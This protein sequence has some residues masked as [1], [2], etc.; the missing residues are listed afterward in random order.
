MMTFDMSP[1]FRS[2]VG[3]DALSRAI[4]TAISQT[5]SGYPPYNIEKTAEDSYRISLAVAGFTADDIEAITNEGV[6]T[7]RGKAKAE[8]GGAAYLYHGIAAR[9]F[10]RRFQLADY[11]EVSGARL[12]NGMLRIDLARRVPEELKARRVE[13]VTSAVGQTASNTQHQIGVAA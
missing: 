2:T 7:V 3:F 4:D 9:A 10:E 8:E 11:V 12:E 5:D 1:L 13:I 6:L